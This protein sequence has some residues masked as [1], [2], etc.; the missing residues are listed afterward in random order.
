VGSL[1]VELARRGHRVT[2]IGHSNAA[3]IVKQLG[4]PLY[5]LP[6]DAVPYRSSWLLWAVFSIFGAGWL[7]GMRDLFRWQADVLL[8]LLP[9]AIKE[10]AIDGLVVD[11][12]F[13]AGGTVAEHLGIPFVTVCSALPW[14]E[15]AGVPP[16]FRHWD[17]AEGILARLRNRLG[18]LP[19]HWYMQPVL[20][21][22]NRYRKAWGLRPF[23]HIDET[24]SPLAQLCQ[25]CPEMDFPRREV[26]SV[27][28]YVGPLATKRPKSNI[29]FPWERLDGR[30][31]IFASL[32]TVSD[33]ANPPMFRKILS[34]CTDID[35][36]LVLALGRWTDQ[37]QF[38]I[39]NELS[40]VP[41]NAIVVD[42][43]PQMAILEKAALLITH[44]GI[45]TVMEAL[46]RGVPIVALPR[47]ADQAGTG[48][49]V[50]YAGVGMRAFFR[51][52]T[53]E[54]LRVMAQRVLTEDGFRRKARQLQQAIVNAGGVERAADIT[55]QAFRKK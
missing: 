2:V 1:G 32:G 28:H 37:D 3:P 49:R 42:F 6:N 10:L 22:I 25:L 21:L 5:E 33:P 40:R 36:Q 43:V 31:L 48:A 13:S 35:A 12:V 29:E 20:T 27:F 17:Y 50:A 19:W 24:C 51:S 41:T 34:A 45:N 14:H 23:R 39:Q 18:Y 47:S 9:K 7:V 11:Q 16:P 55:E 54:Q 4:L 8:Q 15:E 38:S 46:S 30:P 44:A 52:V 53:P 26:P